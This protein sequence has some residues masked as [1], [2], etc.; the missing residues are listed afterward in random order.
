M[1]IFDTIRD[2]YNPNKDLNESTQLNE[3]SKEMVST[4]KKH[5]SEDLKNRV[6]DIRDK[7]SSGVEDDDDDISKLKFINK[8]RV[9]GIKSAEKRISENKE[10][11]SYDEVFEA[12]LNEFNFKS[13]EEVEDKQKFFETVDIVFDMQES[14]AD[15]RFD[16][17][18]KECDELLSKIQSALNEYKKINSSE[19]WGKVYCVKNTSSSLREVL[20]NILSKNDDS[21]KYGKTGLVPNNY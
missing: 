11:I 6:K 5:A 7:K 2:L 13:I 20:D 18:F 15:D 12:V 3:L 21:A 10:S 8:N 16:D 4:Y 17:Y 14:N 9:K 1:N 19:D